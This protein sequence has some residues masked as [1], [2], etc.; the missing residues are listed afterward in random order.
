[1]VEGSQLHAPANLLLGKGTLVSTGLV[2]KIAPA[3]MNTPDPPV[4]SPV[5]ILTTL[6]WVLSLFY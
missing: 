6:S 1:M 4:S 5:T 3:G 2:W